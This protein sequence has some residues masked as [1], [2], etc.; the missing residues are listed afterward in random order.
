MVCRNCKNEVPEGSTVCPVCGANLEVAAAQADKME[1]VKN[2]D[3]MKKLPFA[4]G[5]G[6]LALIALIV[7]IGRIPTILMGS[8]KKVVSEYMKAAQKGKYKK[9]AELTVPK[10]IRD[11]FEDISGMDWADYLDELEDEFGDPPK[12]AKKTKIKIGKAENLDKLDDLE[13]KSNY[14][15][16]DDF[17]EAFERRYGKDVDGDDIS[18]AYIVE[19]K[20]TYDGSTSKTYMYS[21]KYNGKWYVWV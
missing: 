10:D 7:L 12:S 6:I 15:D 1:E 18:K 5:A 16:L 4:I 8:E 21:Y 17:R 3:T 19:V 13:K 2:S 9:I 11:D 20:G 14:D